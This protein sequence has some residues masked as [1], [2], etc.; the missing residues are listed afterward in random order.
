MTRP[1]A[2]LVWLVLC[3]CN[4]PVRF[5]DRAILW[6]EPDTAPIP[7]PAT[8]DALPDYIGLRD[9]AYLPLDRELKLDYFREAVNV[10]ALDEV[11]DSTWFEDLRRIADDRG[12]MRLRSFS[13]LRWSSTSR[14]SS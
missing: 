11:P 3:G 6:R 1:Y 5:S 4:A 8:T 9:V 2:S 12:Q 13:W 10:N 7:V 14:R